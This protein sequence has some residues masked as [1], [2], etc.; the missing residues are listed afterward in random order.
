[1]EVVPRGPS[2]CWCVCV[3]GG[4]L[5]LSEMLPCWVLSNVQSR[6]IGLVCSISPGYCGQANGFR[7]C[8]F[9]PPSLRYGRGQGHERKPVLAT[10][11]SSQQLR[12]AGLSVMTIDRSGRRGGS[13]PSA[14]ER[15]PS[16]SALLRPP[17]G[18]RANEPLTNVCR[19]EHTRA[20]LNRLF[21]HL[22]LSLGSLHLNMH[23]N[24][25]GFLKECNSDADDLGRVG[26]K[27]ADESLLH[28]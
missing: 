23:K 14:K 21:K 6:P 24:Y 26:V 10:V 13:R 5:S 20:N 4:S 2:T 9:S 18:H 15:R 16:L 28:F 22:L 17:H 27:A 19:I 11:T 7:V 3:W 1:M 25:L 12:N 8:L